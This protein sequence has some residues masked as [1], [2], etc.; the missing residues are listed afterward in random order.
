MLAGELLAAGADH[1]TAFRRY[2]EVF[3][4]YAKIGEQG[5]P[6]AFL[7]PR[8]RFGM[9]ARSLMF[10]TAPLMRAMMWLTDRFATAVELREYPIGAPRSEV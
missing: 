3:R 1:T 7:A 2:E 10:R 9:R 4:G 6:G 5:R 8:T